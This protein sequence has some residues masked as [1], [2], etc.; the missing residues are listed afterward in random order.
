MRTTLRAG[1]RGARLIIHLLVGLGAVVA[2]KADVS[3][4]L[5]PER[6][7]RRWSARLLR[8]LAI[9]VRVV[10][11]VLRERHV[12]VA[13]HVSW[14]DITLLSACEDTRFIA[15]SEIRDWP[16][17]GWL[18]NA[19]GTF[20]IRRGKGGARPLVERLVP[21]LAA[22]GSVVLFPEGTTTDGSDVL[23]FH[24]RLFSAP[25]DADAWV[26]PVALRY[27]AGHDGTPVAPFVG[28]DDLVSHIMRLLREPTLSVDVIYCT[29]IR[30]RGLDR[31]SLAGTA[32]AAVRAALGVSSAQA[33]PQPAT[34]LAA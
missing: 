8:I 18:A 31:G 27:G 29:P 34:A 23:P 17:A 22:G 5:Q 12:T 25:I 16:I 6:I 30:A 4:R 15:K 14:L 19:A 20:Y 24:A 2:V 28:D 10:G 26:Q 33:P 1:L 9:R 21:H 7:A 13:N 11:E 32:E 3:G